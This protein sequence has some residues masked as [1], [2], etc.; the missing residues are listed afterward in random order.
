LSNK[1]KMNNS[2]GSRQSHALSEDQ[3]IELMM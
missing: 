1:Q 3:A 2:G